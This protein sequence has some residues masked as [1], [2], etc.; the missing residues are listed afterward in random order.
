LLNRERETH[1]ERTASGN[2]AV[3][4]LLTLPQLPPNSARCV[5]P[6]YISDYITGCRS[7]LR[8]FMLIHQAGVGRSFGE[9]TVR[10]Q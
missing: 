9:H 8:V 4:F 6:L 2:R 3:L 5:S 7:D 1:A 10:K